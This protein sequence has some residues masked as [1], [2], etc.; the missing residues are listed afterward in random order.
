MK[1]EP[2]AIDKWFALQATIPEA[3][4]LARIQHAHDPPGLLALEPQSRSAP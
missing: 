4:M 2:L 3:G 1:S